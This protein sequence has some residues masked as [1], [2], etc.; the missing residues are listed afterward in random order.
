MNG[1][2]IIETDKLNALFEQMEQMIAYVKAA[3]QKTPSLLTTAQVA[4]RMGLSVSTI[5]R[6]KSDIGY[7]TIGGRYMFKRT[8]VEAHIEENY[9]RRKAS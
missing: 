4:E 2:T 3:T 6:I 7:A 5:E 1:V 9:T 8:D